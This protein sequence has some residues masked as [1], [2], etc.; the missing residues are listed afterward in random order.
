M[1]GAVIERS[2][3]IERMAIQS[4]PITTGKRPVPDI[5]ERNRNRHVTMRVRRQCTAYKGEGQPSK[6]FL[7]ISH[8]IPT[9]IYSNHYNQSVLRKQSATS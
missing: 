8:I 2:V 3:F 7:L 1:T 9:Y 4:L 6:Y 5:I